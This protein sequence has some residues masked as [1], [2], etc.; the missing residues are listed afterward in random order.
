VRGGHF[1]RKSCQN[2]GTDICAVERVEKEF[3]NC[4]QN[5][6]KCQTGPPG[7]K[8]ESHGGHKLGRIGSRSGKSDPR[9]GTKRPEV[10]GGHFLRKSC[11]NPGTD[12]CA[13]E[14]V[15]KQFRNCCQNLQ[16]TPGSIPT[17]K[18]NL[19][20][21][22]RTFRRIT[23]LLQE[24]GLIRRRSKKHVNVCPKHKNSS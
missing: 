18:I 22:V 7:S 10:R 2:P 12:I 19:N 9:R 1:L 21:L 6:F 20:S 3:G 15:E 23:L 8:Q 11:Q 13:V 5:L 4:C 24:S 16:R 17:R 14:R